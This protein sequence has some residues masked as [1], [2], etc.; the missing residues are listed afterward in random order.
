MDK[1]KGAFLLV[2]PALLISISII[3]IP[4]IMTLYTSL[5]DWNGFT[6]SMKFIGLENFKYLFGNRYF[7][8]ALKNNIMWT[9][10]FLTIPVVIGMGAALLLLEFKRSRNILQ[11]IFLTPYMLASIVNT[12]I[13]Q[14]IIYNPIAGLIGWLNRLGFD[15]QSPLTMKDYALYAVAGVD[16]WHYWG[17]LAVVYFAALRQTPEDQ[18]EAAKLE[19]ANFFQ[20]FRYIYYPNIRPTFMLMSI[21]IIIFSFLAFDYVYLLTQGGPAHATELLSTLSYTLAFKEF[22]L[23]RASACALFMS[24]FGLLASAI[25]TKLSKSEERY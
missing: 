8:T 11:V 14:N 17:F 10:L 20:Q 16:I 1:N 13:W 19:G 2:L 15:L 21:M 25:Y 12:M 24:M 23:G 4:G 22:K 18:L 6:S 5:T 9:I 7:W 3:I